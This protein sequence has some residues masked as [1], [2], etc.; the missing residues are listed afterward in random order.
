[1]NQPVPQLEDDTRM[2]KPIKV[3]GAKLIPFARAT[4][5]TSGFGGLIWNRPA[6]VLVQH[7]NGEEE[8][9]PIRDVTREMQ[10]KLLLFGLL[11]SLIIWL[12]YKK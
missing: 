7:S 8:V 6:G 5:V 10:I 3:K 2:G 12:G 4:K 9:L 11:G 1:M